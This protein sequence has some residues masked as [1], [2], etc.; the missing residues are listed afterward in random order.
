VP[1]LQVQYLLIMIT[2]PLSSTD[3]SQLPG[4]ASEFVHKILKVKK[5]L[6]FYLYLHMD[7]FILQRPYYMPL[8]LEM[9]HT[10]LVL[11]NKNCLVSSNKKKSALLLYIA[12][13]F[14]YIFPL[15]LTLDISIETLKN[16]PTA[17]R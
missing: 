17:L 8:D 10:I 13:V 15:W 12:T 6:G 9:L 4:E 3:L 14:I 7:I 2:R 16:Y 11:S 1:T 5:N